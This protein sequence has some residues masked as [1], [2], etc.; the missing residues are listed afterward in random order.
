[1]YYIYPK[2]L[3]EVSGCACFQVINTYYIIK[4]LNALSEQLCL[5]NIPKNPKNPKCASPVTSDRPGG[6]ARARPGEKSSQAF[7][8]PFI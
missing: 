7:A 2:K 3:L 1:M 8:G 5:L 6:P 4:R